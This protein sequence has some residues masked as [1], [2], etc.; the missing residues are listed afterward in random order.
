MIFLLFA[1]KYGK[2]VLSMKLFNGG[3]LSIGKTA[4]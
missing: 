4:F 2:K 3:G 1:R